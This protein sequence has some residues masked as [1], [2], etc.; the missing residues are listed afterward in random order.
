[1]PRA[2]KPFPKPFCSP[3]FFE[4]CQSLKT[5][6]PE[7]P[8]LVFRGDR[9]LK[10][11]FEDQ[12]NALIFFHLEE[13]V[14]ARHLIQTLKEDDF[15]RENIAPEMGISRSSFS[16]AIN[17]RGLEQLKYVF[18]KLSIEASNILPAQHADLGNLVA[19]DGSLIDA[20]LSMTWADYRKGSKKAK[21]H[22]GFNLNQGIP[23]KI[24]FTDGK[25]AERPF[26]NQLLS[27]GQTGVGDRGY[28]KH[29]L[30]DLL[31]AEGKSFVIRIKAGTTKTLIKKH[32][33]NP[34]SIV[35]YDAEILLGTVGNNNQTK[36]SVRL[37]GYRVNGIDY[38]IAT[39][40]RD[41]TA[42]QIAQIYKLRWNIENFL[43]GGNVT[44]EYTTSLQEVNTG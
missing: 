13:H 20:V 33:V 2:F 4:L 25:G 38:W 36:E 23:A 9:P 11:T 27:P 35:F 8:P 17:N 34:D 18:E 43:H 30:F 16:E 7:S 37:V 22:L 29:A 39:D 10:M 32:E 42:E 40:R 28:Q 24:F 41:L 21:V 26:V 15:A 19:F 3:S 44:F 1:M 12:L 6:L 14:S 31:Q 5:I